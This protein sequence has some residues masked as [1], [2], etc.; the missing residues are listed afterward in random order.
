M[1]RVQGLGEDAAMAARW[2]K[3]LKTQLGCGGTIDGEDLILLG[4]I[5]ERL[6]KLLEAAGVAHVVRGS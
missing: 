2:L 1:T 4:D 5:G 6:V 3:E